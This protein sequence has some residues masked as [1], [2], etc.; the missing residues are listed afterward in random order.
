MPSF[1]DTAIWTANKDVPA[2]LVVN[3][4]DAV[5]SDAGLEAMLKAHPAAGEMGIEWGQ[6]RADSAAS[7]CGPV[8]TDHG[9]TIP[10][11]AAPVE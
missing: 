10:D 5:L 9:V 8:Y 4:L 2:E 3:A 6:R 1:Q 7:R 11:A